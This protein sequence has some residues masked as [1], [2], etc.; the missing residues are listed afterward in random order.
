[1]QDLRF[2]VSFEFATASE[3]VNEV[4]LSQSLQKYLDTHNLEAKNDFQNKLI[5]ILKSNP[6]YDQIRYIDIN[7]QEIIRVDQDNK[8]N[9]P[10]ISQN[11]QN[12][13]NRYYFLDT[14]KLLKGEM[15][16]SPLDLNVENGIIEQPIK[17]TMRIS[18]PVFHSD[19]SLSGIVIINYQ[20]KDILDSFYEG[21]KHLVNK[22]LLFT[23]SDGYYFKG[24]DPEEEWGFMYKDRT[25]IKFS[26]NYPEAWQEIISNT[27]GIAKTSE[28]IFIFEKIFP[29]VDVQNLQD[30]ADRNFS[31]FSRYLSINDFYMVIVLHQTNMDAIKEF[32]LEMLF[33]VILLLLPPIS[34]IFKKNKSK[35]K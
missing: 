3:T 6:R 10:K 7:G 5:S 24:H 35:S 30:K 12:K 15:Y 9:E 32:W 26:N 25:D 8:T 27:G 23:N 31:Y 17:P 33:F 21:Q 4:S 29:I 34:I 2:Q 19:G 28:G 11:L 22:H 18:T 16:V 14:I 1:M 20:A 13:G